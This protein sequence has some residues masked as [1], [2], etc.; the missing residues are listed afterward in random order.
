VNATPPTRRSLLILAHAA[1]SSVTELASHARD[2]GW[3]AAIY[4]DAET[5][6]AFLDRRGPDA[7]V[8]HWQLPD[9][10]GFEVCRQV[11]QKN[12]YL[13]VVFISDEDDEVTLTRAFD[14]GADDFWVL[15]VGRVEFIVR[16][17][18]HVRKAELLSAALATR[19]I[20]AQSYWFGDVYVDALGHSVYVDGQP[21]QLGTLEYK[22][23]DYLSR[24][25]GIALARDQILGEVYG[26]DPTLD[27]QRVDLLVQ[28]LRKKLGDGPRRG[29]QIVTIRG[30]G[31]R[32]ERRKPPEG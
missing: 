27:T 32:L 9:R 2:R 24:N 13:P 5:G 29:G 12:P 8:T 28:H 21:V 3:E 11:R 18:S 14:S 4:P 17:D 19:L 20:S 26:Y 1:G 6:L 23:L 30:Y 16:L 25:S 10:T 7:L 31:Y 15:P 22:L